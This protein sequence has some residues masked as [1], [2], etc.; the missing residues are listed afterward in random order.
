MNAKVNIELAQKLNDWI[1]KN[2]FQEKINEVHLAFDKVN[3]QNIQFG[4]Y[5]FNLMK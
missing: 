3:Q 1:T 2:S 5:I 4:N